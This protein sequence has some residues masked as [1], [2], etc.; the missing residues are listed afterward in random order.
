MCFC[1]GLNFPNRNAYLAYLQ[2][3]FNLK[4]LKKSKKWKKSKFISA[5]VV[6]RFAFQSSINTPWI[7]TWLLKSGL[8]NSCHCHSNHPQLQTAFSLHCFWCF[9]LVLSLEHGQKFPGLRP[10]DAAGLN[11]PQQ[12]WAE[13][14]PGG[15]CAEASADRIQP[16][17]SEER[18]AALRVA[19]PQNI[20]LACGAASRGRPC[21]VLIPQLLSHCHLSGR[22]LPQRHL[23]TDPH[24]CGRGQAGATA[25]L[26]NLGDTVATN[27]AKSVYRLWCFCVLVFKQCFV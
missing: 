27:R 5:V 19:L 4:C 1:L 2:K 24:T 11:G 16:G 3:N 20:W 25:L 13:T 18:Q 15:A 9:C 23:Q 6:H 10:A 26:Q 8:V 12:K 14:G 21:C 17:A 22:R 7:G